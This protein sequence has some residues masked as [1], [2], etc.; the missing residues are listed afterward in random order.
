MLLAKADGARSEIGDW[1]CDWDCDW[2]LDCNWGIANASQKMRF[3]TD[4]YRRPTQI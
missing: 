1:Q 3:A 4:S 2:D